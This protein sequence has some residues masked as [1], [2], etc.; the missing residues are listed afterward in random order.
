MLDPQLG[1]GRCLRDFLW[2]LTVEWERGYI[3]D[4]DGAPRDPL[5]DPKRRLYPE[6]F[7][8]SVKISMGPAKEKGI[9]VDDLK[10][11]IWKR[12]LQGGKGIVCKHSEA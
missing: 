4:A 12:A 7:L 10:G 1:F 6:G 8:Y 3:A 5:L 11:S 9:A 2:D